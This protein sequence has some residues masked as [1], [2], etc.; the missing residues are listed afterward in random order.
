MKEFATVIAAMILGGLIVFKSDQ[1]SVHILEGKLHRLGLPQE[2]GS[3]A[4]RKHSRRISQAQF[5]LGMGLLSLAIIFWVREERDWAMA[6][7]ATGTVLVV[8]G[9]WGR[10]RTFM[11][12]DAELKR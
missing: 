3:A 1:Q 6:V 2:L 12:A 11:A 10:L 8:L 5:V 4:Y 9:I 7:A